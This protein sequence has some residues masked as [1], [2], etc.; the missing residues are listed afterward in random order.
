M[1]RVLPERTATAAPGLTGLLDNWRQIVATG[2]L[3]R[4]RA[5]DPVSMGSPFDRA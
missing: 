3:P 5:I 1:A 2:N 4:D